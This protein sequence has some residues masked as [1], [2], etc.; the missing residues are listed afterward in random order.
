MYEGILVMEKYPK[1]YDYVFN[2]IHIYRKACTL[3]Y[4]VRDL[5]ILSIIIIITYM[6]K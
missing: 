3:V 4:K 6:S 1:H 2:K 5:T